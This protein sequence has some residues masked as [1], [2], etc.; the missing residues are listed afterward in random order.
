M[1]DRFGVLP[2]P[3]VLDGFVLPRFPLPPVVICSPLP[4]VVV[5][6]LF[7]IILIPL[8]SLRYFE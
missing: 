7:A 4:S 1:F 3:A 6:F 5:C 2:P 8:A